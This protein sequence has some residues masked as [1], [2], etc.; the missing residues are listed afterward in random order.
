MPYSKQ[1]FIDGQ[2]LTAAHLNHIEDGL[3]TLDSTVLSGNIP[4]D[5]TLTQ[6][7]KPADA[8]TTGEAISSIPKVAIGTSSP[9]DEGVKLWIDTTSGM[10][11]FDLPEINDEEVSTTDTWSSKKITQMI[12]ELTYPIGKVIHTTR[13][14]NPATYLGGGTWQ[15]IKDRFLLGA[16]D[17]Y[18]AGSEGGEAKHVLT[19]NEMPNHTHQETFDLGGGYTR[20][21]GDTTQ[22]AYTEQTSTVDG[23]YKKITATTANTSAGSSN[24]LYPI[25]TKAAGGNQ[26]HNNMPPY[27]T[28]YIWERIS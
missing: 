5:T 7:N 24:V 20:P 18:T 19:S 25:V 6:A 8:K 1:T 17:S 11:T 28:V 16:G 26:A 2:V 15:Q 21:I 10:E 4:V 13:P 27:K 22:S 14:E 23:T 3:K 9:T 12:F